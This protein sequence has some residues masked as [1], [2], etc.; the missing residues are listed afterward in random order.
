MPS[1]GNGKGKGTPTKGKGTSAKGKGTSSSSDSKGK[2][3]GASIAPV[4]YKGKSDEPP[5]G[6]WGKKDKASESGK[7]GKGGKG[8]KGKGFGGV[9]SGPPLTMPTIDISSEVPTT[10][11]S[12]ETSPPSTVSDLQFQGG[13]P[14]GQGLSMEVTSYAVSY[15]YD[16]TRRAPND[17]DFNALGKATEIFLDSFFRDN[18]GYG[19]SATVFLYELS[20]TWRMGGTVTTSIFATTVNFLPSS[21]KPRVEDLNSAVEFAF[22]NPADV[23][24]YIAA[25]DK[26]AK[27]NP[28]STT[29]SIEFHW[30]PVSTAEVPTPRPSPRP[31]AQSKDIKDDDENETVVPKQTGESSAASPGA[32]AGG[33]GAGVFALLVSGLLIWRRGNR[34]DDEAMGKFIDDVDGDGDGDGHVTVAET[35]TG[36]THGSSVA[37]EQQHQTAQEHQQHYQQQGTQNRHSSITS[38]ESTPVGAS[39]W[40]SFQKNLNHENDPAMSPQEWDDMREALS[41]G[42]PPSPTGWNS[43]LLQNVAEE[44]HEDEFS[45]S[46]GSASTEHGPLEDV[47]L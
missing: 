39:N 47:R 37:D 27:S 20:Q 28:Y 32:L 25:L 26:M 44:E 45:Y 5:K 42:R 2:G 35:F 14:V 10:L 9:P 4:Y 11:G 43:S 24:N 13:S 40:D 31:V 33:V 7:G 18:F 21:A 41:A 34:V 16:Q 15:T 36:E 38:N 29:T 12:G 17:N 3:K 22:T 19:T 23:K 30:S 8:A 1:K 6:K 46:E